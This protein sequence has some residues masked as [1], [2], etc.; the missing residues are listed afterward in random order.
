MIYYTLFWLENS[1]ILTTESSVIVVSES[2]TKTKILTERTIF[3]E[4]RLKS[5]DVL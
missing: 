3:F 2:E 4:F 5:F 1:L